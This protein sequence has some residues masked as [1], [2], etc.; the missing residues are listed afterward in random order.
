MNGKSFWLS[1]QKAQGPLG[2]MDGLGALHPGSLEKREKG[3]PG[4]LMDL[5]G[6][7][8]TGAGQLSV[9]FSPGVLSLTGS[10]TQSL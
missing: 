3:H 2:V 1:S 5:C 4:H 9:D 6:V 8:F 7:G 10:G